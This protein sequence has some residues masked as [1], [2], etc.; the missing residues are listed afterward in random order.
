MIVFVRRGPMKQTNTDFW[1]RLQS[2]SRQLQDQV[3]I[4]PECGIV[5]GS[6]LG[7]LADQVEDPLYVDFK[8]IEGLP[9]STAPGHVG[10]FVFGRLHGKRVALMQGR[11]HLYEGYSAS[12]C[13]LPIRLLGL[14]GLRV[15]VLTNAAGAINPDYQ[16]GDFCLLTDQITSFVPSPLR[17]AHH[18]E[19]GPRFP[20]MSQVYDPILR[21]QM[22]EAGRA[23]GCRMQEGVYIQFTGPAYET[24]AEIRL[25]RSL[26]ADMVGMSTAIEACA[27]R[28]MGMRVVGVSFASNKAA[29]LSESPLTET[30][31]IE[32]GRRQ[33]DRFQEM[34]LGFLERL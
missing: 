25:A 34:I 29:G 12:D 17:G 31:V 19:L 1:S 32:E 7:A 10:R 13:V 6:G 15:L 33:A 9:V 14:L 5:L 8:D 24:P 30:E 26:G 16:V 2:C 28:H 27:A 11:I 3:T 23:A 18:P 4:R 21:A 20:D 22:L